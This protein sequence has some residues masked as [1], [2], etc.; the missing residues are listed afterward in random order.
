MEVRC[1]KCQAR[2]RV[3]DEKIGPQGL[4]MKCGKCQ[5]QFRVSR[6]AA[7]PAATIADQSPVPPRPAM[8]PRLA[9]APAPAKPPAAAVPKRPEPESNATMV[10]GQSP[11]A[12]AKP[13]AA[14]PPPASSASSPPAKVPAGG[15]V[16]PPVARPATPAVNPADEGAGRTMMFQTGNVK[17]PPPAVKR[18]PGL[19][20]TPAAAPESNATLMFGQSKVAKPAAP[21]ARAAPVK[22]PGA[23][24]AENESGAT[25]VFGQSPIAPAAPR[26]SSPKPPQLKPAVPGDSA[27]ATVM[28]GSGTDLPTRQSAPVAKAAPPRVE[29]APPFEPEASAI[30]A[31][32]PQSEA[33]TESRPSVDAALDEVAGG[34]DGEGQSRSASYD[35]PEGQGGVQVDG[36]DAGEDSPPEEGAEGTFDKAPPRGLLIGIAAGAAALVLILIASVVWK[37]MAH[38]APPPAALEALAASQTAASKDSL[39]SL[40][41]AEAK[42]KD[43]IEQAGGKSHFSRGP[44]QL[45]QVDVQWADALNDQATLLSTRNASETDEAKKSAAETKIA[46]LQSQAKGKLKVAFDTLTVAI[47]AEAKSPDLELALAEYYRAQG[48]VSNMNKELRKAQA[49]KA[50]EAHVSLVQ[51]EALLQEDDGGEK[52]VPKLKAALAA[53]PQ[54][55]R[56]HF[57]LAQ[58]DVSMKNND[59]ALKELKQVLQLSPQHERAKLLM[60]QIATTP[61]Q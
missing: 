44:A 31:A 10:F 57:R 15:P 60:E 55:A 48:S 27:G 20:L 9:P 12:P 59:D 49:L 36:L 43:A 52:A 61:A 7:A 5:N 17:A 2:Y 42:A 23:Q 56:I 3:A 40:A 53:A 16:K 47:R 28:F 41:D 34:E 1:D 18:P 25:M 46:E 11:I 35:A 26:P 21:M 13:V 58:A 8:P 32:D 30:T 19:T 50:D 51:G 22:P 45:A 33:L 37:K 39:A 14:K 29:Q 6:E 24:P 54:S 38:H 4:T